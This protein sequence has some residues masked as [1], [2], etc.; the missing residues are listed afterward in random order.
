MQ[1]DFV[2]NL[3][4]IAGKYHSFSVEKCLVQKSSHNTELSLFFL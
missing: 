3:H 2:D 1:T 4:A